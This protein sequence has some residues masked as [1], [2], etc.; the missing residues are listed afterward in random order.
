MQLLKKYKN[1]VLTALA[2]VGIISNAGFPWHL[3]TYNLMTTHFKYSLIT[4]FL[5]L[6]AIQLWKKDF[7]HFWYIWFSL[8]LF[9]ITSAF[10][11]FI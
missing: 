4:V 6:L 8:L 3:K 11:H 10:L 5:T 2:I 9:L 1:L 7:F